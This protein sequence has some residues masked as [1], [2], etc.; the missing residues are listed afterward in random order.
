[1][2]GRVFESWD[3]GPPFQTARGSARAVREPC[4]P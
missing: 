1:M 4:P 2:Q 3:A